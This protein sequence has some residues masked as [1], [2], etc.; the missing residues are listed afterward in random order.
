[1]ALSIEDTESHSSLKEKNALFFGISQKLWIFAR[2]QYFELYE[3]GWGGVVTLKMCS[4]N[5]K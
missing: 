2:I 3:M 4:E 1:M 5:S